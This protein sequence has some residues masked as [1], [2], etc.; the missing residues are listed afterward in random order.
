[1]SLEEYF[2]EIRK[3]QVNMMKA[4]PIGY[5]LVWICLMVLVGGGMWYFMS[6]PVQFHAKCNLGHLGVAYS[7]KYTTNFTKPISDNP[8]YSYP[9][10]GMRKIP[11]YLSLDGID[12]V[13]CDVEAK[14]PLALA[15]V[16]K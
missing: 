15:W 16:M 1:M 7:E 11:Q 5:S 13:S 6:M 12:D 9:Y 2:R 4:S 10:D 14:F 3:Y 8:Y